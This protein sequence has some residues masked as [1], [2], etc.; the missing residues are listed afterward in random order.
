[1][2]LVYGR[3]DQVPLTDRRPRGHQGGAEPGSFVVCLP[4]KGEQPKS[5]D[6]PNRTVYVGA[7]R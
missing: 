7:S 3:Y 4:V 1:M 5:I 2:T 6:W